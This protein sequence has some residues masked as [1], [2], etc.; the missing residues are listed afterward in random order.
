MRPVQP[1]F[2][3]VVMLD[4]RCANNLKYTHVTVQR[5]QTI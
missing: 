5:N 2:R 4:V 3:R 1:D